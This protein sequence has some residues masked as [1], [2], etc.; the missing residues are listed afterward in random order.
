MRRLVLPALFTVALLVTCSSAAQ[1]PPTATPGELLVGLNLGEPAFQVGAVKGRTV[2]LARGFE[3]DLARL[4]GRRLG[5]LRVRFVHEPVF[6]RLY[7]R[8]PKPWDLAIASVTIT[9]ERRRNVDFSRPYLTADQGVL[10]AEGVAEPR[11]LADLRRLQLCA[12]RGTVSVA[13]IA[14]RVKPTRKPLLFEKQEGLLDAL[15]QRRCQAVVH[16]APLLAALER[17]AP[18]RYGRLV[19][20]LGTPSGYGVVLAK[21][22]MLTPLV[23]RAL[24]SLQREGVLSRLQRRWLGGDVSKLRVLG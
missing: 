16:D 6:G 12:Q 7:S 20:R 2:V 11:K 5:V 15:Y 17:A 23:N 13:A 1:P 8:R 3:I 18:D 4:L 14:Q 24:A 10:L 22:G 9:P 21:A 19:A